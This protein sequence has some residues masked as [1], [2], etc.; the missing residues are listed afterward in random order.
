MVVWYICMYTYI[1]LIK[2][3]ITGVAVFG[4][5]DYIIVHNKSSEAVLFPSWIAG[6]WKKQQQQKPRPLDNDDNN[7]EIATADNCRKQI[8]MQASVQPDS[9]TTTAK[10]PLVVHFA[11][12]A[13]AG[14]MQSLVLDAWEVGHYIWRTHH[15]H[16]SVD[17]ASSPKQQQAKKFVS[18]F[19]NIN[20]SLIVR[21]ALHHAVGYATLFGWYES[22]RR[23]LV[24]QTLDYLQHSE[25]PFVPVW[26]DIL[27]SCRLIHRNPNNGIYD[28]TILPISVAFCAG[29]I[30]GQAHY[31]VSHLLKQQRQQLPRQHSSSKHQHA[32]LVE[33]ATKK[34]TTTAPTGTTA[35][36]QQRHRPG[37]NNSFFKRVKPPSLRATMGAFLP[38]ALS[39][40]AFQY[41]G[42]LTERWINDEVSPFPV[43][44]WS[45][46]DGG[47]GKSRGVSSL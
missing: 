1:G 14:L 21:R 32:I 9:H 36:K 13:T 41:G 7:D 47:G 23:Y 15:F 12:G 31:V 10:V 37:S 40:V 28:M 27:E 39:F 42:E 33:Q 8:W 38:T 46:G 20:T 6:S 18:L 30:A 26:L 2:S 24:Q 43:S 25:S 19:R 3:G 34:S 29:G 16:H 17:S 44:I 35:A 45:A 11:A 4:T 5:Y 22:I